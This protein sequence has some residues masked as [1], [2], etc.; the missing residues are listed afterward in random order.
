M[1]CKLA[2]DVNDCLV[3]VINRGVGNF[4]SNSNISIG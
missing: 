1:W 4:N 3:M 2:E